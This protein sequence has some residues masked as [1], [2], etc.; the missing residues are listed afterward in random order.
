MTTHLTREPDGEWV[1][2]ACRTQIAADGI[3]LCLGTLSDARGSI[4]EVSQPLLVRAR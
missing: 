2:L 4:G 3:G 1:H